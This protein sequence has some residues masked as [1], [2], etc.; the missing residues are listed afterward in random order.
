VS[1]F[2]AILVDAMLV[3]AILVDAILVDVFPCF[4]NFLNVRAQKG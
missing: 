3:D 1:L 2:L 4:L